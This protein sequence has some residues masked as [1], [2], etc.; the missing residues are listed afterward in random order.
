MSGGYIGSIFLSE[1]SKML[2]RGWKDT[3]ATRGYVPVKPY[4]PRG[5]TI[6]NVAR[7]RRDRGRFPPQSVERSARRTGF[8]TVRALGG[9]RLQTCA[10]TNPIRIC[11]VDFL[12]VSQSPAAPTTESVSKPFIG[13]PVKKPKKA[14]RTRTRAVGHFS[15]VFKGQTY[16]SRS[17]AGVMREVFRLLAREDPT[18]LEKFAKLE[19]GRKRRYLAQNPEELY[20]GRPDLVEQ[21]SAEVAPGW[22]LG[23]HY[24][25]EYMQKILNLALGVVHPSLRSEIRVNMDRTVAAPHTAK[26]FL[27]RRIKKTARCSCQDDQFVRIQ[28]TNI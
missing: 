18:F 28:R 27:Q 8:I 15:F 12:T 1:T 13:S 19:H 21:A 7:D 4:R 3:S 17:V 6:R 16:E 25:R 14:E 23:T 26:K 22:W 24:G 10:V 5:R 9:K 11:V 20:P 2:Q